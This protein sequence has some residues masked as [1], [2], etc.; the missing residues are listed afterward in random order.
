MILIAAVCWVIGG[1]LY[2]FFREHRIRVTRKKIYY[3]IATGTIVFLV[4]NTLFAAL[5]RGDASVVIPI[6]NLSFIIALVVSVLLGMESLTRRKSMAL[7]LA[8]VA[9]VLLSRV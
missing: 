8:C 4:V 9:I 1:F 5:A 2:A 3:S 7:A 6:A